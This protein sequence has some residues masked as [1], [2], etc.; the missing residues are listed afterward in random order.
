[1]AVGADVAHDEA[2]D[3]RAPR[4]SRP[5]P[6]VESVD[7]R[8]EWPVALE[9]MGLVAP[10]ESAGSGSLARE[11]AHEFG[12][13]DARLALNHHHRGRTAA[14]ALQQLSAKSKFGLSAQKVLRA[15]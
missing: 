15:M 2:T 5:L 14:H 8:A 9:S 6:Q 13:P 3:I 10:H 1:M 12:L 7:E 11:M 4:V